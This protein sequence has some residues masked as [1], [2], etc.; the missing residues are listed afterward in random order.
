MYFR[1]EMSILYVLGSWL[2]HVP[3]MKPLE[4]IDLAKGGRETHKCTHVALKVHSYRPYRLSERQHDELIAALNAARHGYENWVDIEE[5]L[6]WAYQLE[7]IYKEISQKE[8]DS[9]CQISP[10]Q[11]VS[12]TDAE[13]E[14]H[15]SVGTQTVADVQE[16]QPSDGH[17]I[18]RKTTCDGGLAEYP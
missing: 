18:G 12:D 13:E 16:S 11:H 8:G 6:R 15:E 9:D 3:E 17:S 5:R 10:D 7:H 4:E 14:F 2:D 1:H